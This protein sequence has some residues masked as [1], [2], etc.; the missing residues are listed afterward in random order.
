MKKLKDKI[1]N[2][3]YTL[4]CVVIDFQIKYEMF[5]NRK[6]F[7][8]GDVVKYN[9]KAKVYIKSAIK[10]KLEPRVVK[11]YLYKDNSGVEFTNGDGCDPF[12]VSK[13]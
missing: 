11:N 10:D 12:W 4:L 5:D 8:N 7:K 3:F 1:S 2:A 13:V 9:W 6:C